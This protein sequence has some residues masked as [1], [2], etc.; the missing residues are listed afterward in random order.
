MLATMAFLMKGTPFIY[1]GDE[2]GMTNIYFTELSD[3]RDIEIFNTYRQFVDSGLVAREDMMRYF[4]L[5][6]RDNGRTP[7]QWNTSANAG[8]T[9]LRTLWSMEI[10][11]L[12]LKIAMKY[13]HM[14]GF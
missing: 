11:Y 2:L 14:R 12:C 10:L 5:L 13:M 1:Q 9:T 8:F 4:A 7:M 6:G 3:Y